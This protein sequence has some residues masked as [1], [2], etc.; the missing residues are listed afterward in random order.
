MD[1]RVPVYILAGGRS[2]RFGSDK[3]RATFN[4]EPLILHVRRLLSPVAL[5]VTVVA[6]HQD[7]YADLSLRTIADRT[8]N[9]GPLGGLATALTDNA[10]APWLLLC[11]CD[12]LVIRPDWLTRLLS[13]RTPDADAIAFRH[14]HWQPMPALFAQTS[15]AVVESQ[16]NA[17]R[18]SMQQLLNQL[19][20]VALPTP[21]NWPKH[22]QVN[23][24]ADL[25]RNPFDK[26][27]QPPKPSA[28]DARKKA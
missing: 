10:E 24:P 22:W 4:D 6:E 19:R 3:A 26:H 11:A 21:R 9:L 1:S 25:K 8:P 15:A 18:R 13:H 28:P 2:Q 12:A 23:R 16:L 14:D 17:E 20:T 7:K 5:S 27:S